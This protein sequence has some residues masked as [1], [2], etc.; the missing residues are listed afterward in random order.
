MASA[1][2][3]PLAAERFGEAKLAVLLR[4]AATMISWTSLWCVLMIG[5]LMALQ[6]WDEATWA[7][8]VRALAA[9]GSPSEVSVWAGVPLGDVD[10]AG[11][12]ID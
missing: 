10:L 1:H 9:V 3:T 8:W 4:V 7:V 12:E 2:V 5:Y 11:V 6:R